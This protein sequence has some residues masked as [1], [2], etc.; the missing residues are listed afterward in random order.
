VRS[1]LFAPPP[2]LRIE[3]LAVTYTFLA[4]S[5]ERD[6]FC[7]RERVQKGSRTLYLA[8][9]NGEGEV[10][11]RAVSS[12]EAKSLIARGVAPEAA[13]FTRQRRA[14]V[15]E[16]HYFELDD[17][18]DDPSECV[19][20]VEVPARDSPVVFPAWLLPAVVKPIPSENQQN[21]SVYATACRLSA[22]KQTP[23]V[24]TVA[25]TPASP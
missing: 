23:V 22:T 25:A 14:F 24:A 15:T 20:Q 17:I 9:K 19:L 16:H 21:Y 1:A 4:G 5:N 2:G 12:R 6:N 7:I 11:E 18:S 10:T 8:R 3:E 13:R